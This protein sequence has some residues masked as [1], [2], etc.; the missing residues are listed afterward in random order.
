MSPVQVLLKTLVFLCTAV[1]VAASAASSPGP[2]LPP[3]AG[4]WVARR[5]PPVPSSA[6]FAPLSSDTAKC[7]LLCVAGVAALAGTT[8]E[9][10]LG[11]ASSP[12]AHRPPPAHRLRPPSLGFFSAVTGGSGAEGSAVAGTTC[13]PSQR[14]FP[15]AAPPITALFDANLMSAHCS[16]LPTV[17]PPSFTENS[18]HGDK[19]LPKALQ[20]RDGLAAA[21]LVDLHAQR[22]QTPS[23]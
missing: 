19:S 15:P 10:P 4:T 18:P 12:L 3:S 7:A 21:Q 9:A 20:T 14:L 6:A 2:L 8:L 16:A 23:F 17:T 22:D 1:A 11:A 13:G 5:A